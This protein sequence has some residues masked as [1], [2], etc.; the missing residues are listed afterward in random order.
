MFPIG[1]NGASV[2]DRENHMLCSDTAVASYHLICYNCN[3]DFIIEP[4]LHTYVLNCPNMFDISTAEFVKT[5]LHNSMQD[6]CPKCDEN[7]HKITCFYESPNII[8]LTLNGVSCRVS[9]KITLNQDDK[10]TIYSLKG[11]VYFGE[12]HFTA[13][14]C[15]TDGTVWYH[16]GMD[17]VRECT[18]ESKLAEM[19]STDLIKCQ[20]RKVALVIYAS[21]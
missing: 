11:I 8:A 16:D 9:K 2:T 7:M 21:K 1:S 15:Q 20:E 10:A 14:V 13:H 18:Y 12:F 6:K 19:T 5:V 4:D 3:T 17:R